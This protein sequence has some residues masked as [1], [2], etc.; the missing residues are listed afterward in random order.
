MASENFVKR[1]PGPVVQAE[2]KRLEE[3]EAQLQIVQRH[4]SE[5]P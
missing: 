5:L 4:R 2:R 1:A 3:H